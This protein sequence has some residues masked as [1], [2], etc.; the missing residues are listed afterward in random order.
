M[1]TRR[2]FLGTLGAFGGAVLSGDPLTALTRARPGATIQWGYAAITWGVRDTE[3]ID[4]ISALGFAGI[5]L[6]ANVLQQFG[7]RPA[8]LKELLLSRK[9]SLV[10]LSSG[11]VS[12]DPARET[13]MIDGHVTR[14]RF[15]RDVGGS[16]LQVTDE[17]PAGRAVTAD[18]ITRLGK[19]L[20]D[21]GR[22]TADLG[23]PLGY[24]NHMGTIGESPA[25]VDRVLDACDPKLVR[26]ELDIAHYHQGGGKPA[27]AIRRHRDRL[28]FLHM[29]DVEATAPAN[30]GSGYR[31]VELGRGAVD[32]KATMAAL[33]A[34]DYLGWAVI[35]L[36]S[37]PA[38][39]PP[40]TPKGC[41]EISMRY[42]ETAF[43]IRIRT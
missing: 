41:A 30:G 42:L 31:F 19:L 17:K 9:L 5:Q 24:H 4:D 27:D 28:L 14:A 26:F 10:A 18:D 39:T 35:E 3:A 40:R 34:V 2:D 7:D 11:G 21:I 29:K 38:V 23:V 16:Y 32:L 33:D 13:Q 37:V 6:R 25:D 12:L 20:T 1:T 8:A 22:R 36:D 43:G 15:L